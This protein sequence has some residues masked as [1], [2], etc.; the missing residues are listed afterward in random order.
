MIS[1]LNSLDVAFL[2]IIS[3][4]ILL[5]VLKGFIRELFSLAFFLIAVILS[6]LFYHEVGTFYLKFIKNRD[7]SNFTGFIT[8]FIIVIIVGSVVTYLIKKIFT[9][10]PLKS[11]DRILGGLFGLVRGVLISG[12]IVFGFI[13]FKVNDA[14]II[15]SKLSPYLIHT[16]KIFYKLLPENIKDNSSYYFKNLKEKKKPL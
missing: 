5:G 8:I 7:I 2:V 13:A 4:S 15:K 14:L 16:V 1:G 12:I 3:I 11:V 6:F 10:G 9:L